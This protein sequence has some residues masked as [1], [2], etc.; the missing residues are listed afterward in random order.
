MTIRLFVAI[1][2]PDVVKDVLA[3]TVVYL[4]HNLPKRAVRWVRREQMHLTLRFLGDTA[5]SQLPTLQQ[6]LTQLAARHQPFWLRLNDVGAFPNRKRPRVLWA[7]LAGDLVPLQ[8]MQAELEERVVALGWMREKRPFNPH[9]T[10]GRVKDVGRVRDFNWDVQ[11]DE[12]AFGVTAVRLMQ[13]ELRP[14]GAV[15]TIQ[16]EAKLTPTP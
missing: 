5:V 1:E 11:V 7:G 15:Y 14:S 2:L 12:V 3:E 9:L 13:S 8:K 6:K 16:H 10:L 4:N